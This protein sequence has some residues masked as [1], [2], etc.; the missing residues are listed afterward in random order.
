[1]KIKLTY[2]KRADPDF[3]CEV[4][5]TLPD[6]DIILRIGETWKA[7]KE[8]AIESVKALRPTTTPPEPEEVEL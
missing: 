5:A 3:P 4:R 7:A 2:S 6:G 1:M 8:R